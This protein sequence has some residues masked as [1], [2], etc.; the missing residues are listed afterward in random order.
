[1]AITQAQREAREQPARL[2]LEDIGI[3]VVSTGASTPPAPGTRLQD[4]SLTVLLSA[5]APS[6]MDTNTLAEVL[7]NIDEHEVSC[8]NDDD[9]YF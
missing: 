4:I 3:E 9:N 1:M 5:A 6:S 7:A 8:G 2:R